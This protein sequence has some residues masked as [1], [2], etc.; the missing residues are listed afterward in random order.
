MTHFKGSPSNWTGCALVYCDVVGSVFQTRPPHD[1]KLLCVNGRKKI[2]ALL[3][4]HQ[5]ISLHAY[6]MH[7]EREGAIPKTAKLES[8][9]RMTLMIS[10]MHAAI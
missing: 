8:K 2:L 3:D 7:T 1:E 6:I 10:I 9:V 4:Q 5:I